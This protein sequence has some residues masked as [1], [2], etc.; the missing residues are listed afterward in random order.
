MKTNSYKSPLFP[1]CEI[2]TMPQRSPMWH[3][4]RGDKLTASQVGSWLAEEKKCRLE[5]KEIESL[6]DMASINYPKRASKAVLLEL[7]ETVDEIPLSHSS[8]TINA[9]HTA[10]CKI[11][12]DI[13]GCAVPDQW[14][15]EPDGPPP[16]NPAMWAI[17]NGI[18]MED[19][20]VRAFEKWSGTTIVHV[21]FCL[22][23]SNVA[24][25]SPDGLLVREPVGFEGKAP[26]PATHVNYVLN[27][28]ALIDQYG[29]QCHFSMA[30]TGAKAWW[31]QSYCPGLPAAR[32]LI[33]RDEYTERM[34]EGLEEFA[35]SLE[36]ARQEIAALWDEE[37]EGRVIA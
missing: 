30:V 34:V 5:N 33:Q 12:G 9:S 11:L 17:W 20:A 13:S 21:G 22:H 15:V 24:G 28:Q 3:D 10:I 16:R 32:V 2:Y 37:F 36:S 6:L 35:E 25:C 1:D 19:E 29:D 27:R 7:L 26:L 31:L 14:E 8:A 18:R 4:M 23:K